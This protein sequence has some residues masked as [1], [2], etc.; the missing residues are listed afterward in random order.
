M[1]P[2]TSVVAQS[3]KDQLKSA[4]AISWIQH[5]YQLASFA[6]SSYPLLFLPLFNRKVHHHQTPLDPSLT[7]FALSFFS[8]R[9]LLKAFCKFNECLNFLH[10]CVK[11]RPRNYSAKQFI[12]NPQNVNT[13]KQSCKQCVPK[14][15]EKLNQ[16][17]IDPTSTL[18][19]E[20]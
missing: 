1:S 6:C 2:L 7:S 5:Q 10:F 9:P 16:A 8:R 20:N 3:S 14:N 11:S 12:F 15:N 17:R 19:D 18:N 4:D 13:H